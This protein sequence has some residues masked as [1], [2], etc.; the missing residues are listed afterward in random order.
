MKYDVIVVGAGAI[1]SYLAYKLAS[2]GYC[3]AVFERKEK[4]DGKICCSG[5][6]STECFNSFP[7]GDEVVLREASSV[8]VFAPSGASFRLEKD[9]V[10][11]YIIDRPALNVHLAD[12]AQANGVIYFLSARVTD[13][14]PKPRYVQVNIDR[15]GEKHVFEARAVALA[16]GLSNLPQRLGLGK[17]DDF[18]LGA[19][20]EVNIHG[21]DEVEV[22]LD[23]EMAP[24][25]FAW[26]V[27]TS[28]STGLVGSLSCHKPASHLERLLSRLHQQGKISLDGGD[29][30]QKAIPI[31]TLPRTYAER[32]IAVGDAAG[33]VKP[34]TG[35]GIYFGLLCADIA[36]ESLRRALAVDDLSARRL[37][38]YEREWKAKIDREIAIGYWLRR[39]YYRMS[40][41][42][43]EQVFNIVKSKNIHELLLNSKAFSFDWHGKLISSALREPRL[44]TALIFGVLVPFSRAQIRRETAASR[45]N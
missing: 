42:Q 4:L 15:S 20:A 21:I 37:S 38:Q 43:I 8:K 44:L 34:T 7:I 24:G 33:Q 31:T 16:C 1:G 2:Y 14:I 3:V 27:P 40:Q 5:I 13:I 10:Q 41:K 36:A 32:I 9:A 19:Q 29:L 11:A 23:Q 6:I 26:L 17:I 30:K 45:A 12:K 35:G 22:Y 39:L 25:F 28:T 18:A